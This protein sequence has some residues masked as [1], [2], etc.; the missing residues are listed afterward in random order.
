MKLKT[1]IAFTAAIATILLLSGISQIETAVLHE[2]VFRLTG[3]GRVNF[4]DVQ[5]GE[6][7]SI[8]YRDASGAYNESALDAVERVL[9]CHGDHETFPISLK[10]IELID[11]IQDHFG[12]DGVMVVSGYRSPEYNAALKRRIK[13]VAHDSLHMKGLAMDIRLAGIGKEE[14]GHYARSLESGG[15]GVYHSS[16]FVHIDAGPVR[17]W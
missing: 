4:T 6:R 9:R 1:R 16:N 8:V 17:S 14:L 11:H 10:L 3:D 12:V 5:T 13:R 15:V 2:S 7:L